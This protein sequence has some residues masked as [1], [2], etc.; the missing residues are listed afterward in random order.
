MTPT[1]SSMGRRES[2]RTKRRVLSE[3]TVDALRTKLQ[4]P[5]EDGLTE[6]ERGILLGILESWAHLI[7]VV[8]TPTTGIAEVRRLLG[9][10][11]ARCR[12]QDQPKPPPPAPQQPDEA[13]SD[14]PPTDEGG[15]EPAGDEPKPPA[16]RRNPHGRRKPGD[17]QKLEEA[18]HVHDVLRCGNT[19]PECKRGRLYKYK[20]S[21]FTTVSGRSPL[22]ATRHIVETLQCNLCK[23]LFKAPLPEELV[24]DGV[25]ERPLYTYSAVAVAAVYR[26]FGGL[27]MHRQQMLQKALG[28]AVPDASIWD[29]CE[30]LADALRPIARVLHVF[31]ADATLLYGDDTGATILGTRNKVRKNRR[32]G[33]STVRTG[34]HTTCIIAVTADG[35]AIT[36]FVTGIHH[37]GEVMDLVLQF[38]DGTLAP[39]VFM[40]DCIAS[41][42]VT[43]TL[44]V[45][46]GCNAHAVRKFKAIAERYPEHADYVLSRYKKIYENDE[47]CR[48][49]GMSP[50]QRRDCHRAQS[51]P[52][53]NEICEYGEDLLEQRKIEPNS[54]VGLAFN[55][56]IENKRR[57]SAFARHVNAPLDNNRCE[58]ELRVCI[59]LRDTARFFRNVVGSGVADTVLTVGATA[60]ASGVNL[61]DYFVAVQ[62]HAKDVRENPELWLPW[63]WQERVRQLS[64]PATDRDATA[65][66]VTPLP[67]SA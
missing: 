9:L 56:V 29:M 49:T 60:L 26:F 12:D 10:S 54:D 41:N 36:L 34:C 3:E 48:V 27:P 39:S 46:A 21:E 24:A 55:Y 11:P 31:A 47:H 58:R 15:Q 30:R 28:V 65:D 19:C 33:A 5:P 57:L 18:H 66:P 37:T 62:R 64:G 43:T 23:A 38:R 4:G 59:R 61:I 13:G 17:F 50:E 52:L 45:H 16:K 42:T 1:G 44:V 2:K 63:C 67:P 32:T 25:Q 7:E 35:R 20:P 22:V 8:A 40:G 51:L 6:E 53:L 14:A